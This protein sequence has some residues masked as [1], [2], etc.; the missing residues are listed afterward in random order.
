MMSLPNSFMYVWLYQISLSRFTNSH[1]SYVQFHPLAYIVKL[2]IELSMADLISKIVR[3]QDRVDY[4]YSN[5]NPTELTSNPRHGHFDSK[6]GVFSSQNEQ[7]TQVSHIY[8]TRRLSDSSLSEGNIGT[9]N[10]GVGIMKTVATVVQSVEK[11]GSE[12]V[13]SSMRQLNEC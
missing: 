10:K 13:S 11:D 3:R 4:P 6:S 5:S 8:A 12:S 9:Q 7:R 1:N 2:N